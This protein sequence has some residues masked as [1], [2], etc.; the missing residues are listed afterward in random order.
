VAEKGIG[1]T[2]DVPPH[3]ARCGKAAHDQEQRDD[4]QFEA[5][6]DGRGF[7]SDDGKGRGPVAQQAEGEHAG[8]PHRDADGYVRQDHQEQ[9]GDAQKTNGFGAHW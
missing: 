5:G 1:Q 2:I 9:G 8:D 4:R 3:A 6:K 7:G